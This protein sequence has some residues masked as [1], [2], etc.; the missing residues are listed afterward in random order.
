M[1]ESGIR[2]RSDIGTFKD[3]DVVLQEL[4]TKMVDMSEVDKS[5]I[6]G[7]LAGT[8]QSNMILALVDNMDDL[9]IA[10]ENVAKAG[11]SSKNKMDI[12][13]E[14]TKAKMNELT[15]SL[16]TMYDKMFNSEMIN[17]AI[18]GLTRFIE[19]ITKLDGKTVAMGIAF[20]T[21]LKLM[22][23]SLSTFKLVSVMKSATEATGLFQKMMYAMVTPVAVV[24]T[25]SAVASGAI[26]STGVASAVATP[27]VGGLG[28]GFGILTTGIMSSLKAMGTF[29]MSPLGLVLGALALVIGAVTFAFAHNAKEQ[30]KFKEKV[31]A[32][33]TSV[34]ALNESLEAMNTQGIKDNMKPLQ[35]QQDELQKL[36][37]EKKKSDEAMAGFKDKHDR[38]S[39]A[40]IT[41][42][43]LN[44]QITE[45]L[46]E[47]TKELDASGIAYDSVT[48]KIEKLNESQKAIEDN[49]IPDATKSYE[50]S[51][52]AL[53]GMEESLNKINGLTELS[54]DLQSELLTKYPDAENSLGSVASAQ[55]FLNG[56]I[57]E[58][59]E[60]QREAY[61]IMMGDDEE[62]YN[63]KLMND[64]N[65]KNSVRQNLRDLGLSKEEANAFDFNGYKTL[66]SLKNGILNQ[67]GS[68][69]NSWLSSFVSTS[70]SGY[71]IDLNNF[72][73]AGEAKLAILN[74]IDQ[75]VAK[76]NANMGASVAMAQI[77]TSSMGSIGIKGTAGETLRINM[78]D[79]ANQEI[80]EY[81]WKLQELAINRQRVNT[82]LGGFGGDFSGFSPSS[83][84]GGGIS[85]GDTGGS[86]IPSG[87]DDDKAKKG[88]Q[89]KKE[90]EAE[91]DVA[92]IE[93]KTD[94]YIN[95]Q[96][97]IKK[98][99]YQMDEL[100]RLKENASE[101]EKIN[102]I[103][104]EI[105][106]LGTKRKKLQ[107]NFEEQRKET[108]ALTNLLSSQ[109]HLNGDGTID[110]EHLEWYRRM[111]NE[112]HGE[113]KKRLQEVYSKAVEDTKAYSKLR[114]TDLE[115]SRKE[116]NEIANEKIKLQKE[117]AEITKKQIS[118][119]KDSR[120]KNINEEKDKKIKAIQE[121]KDKQIKALDEIKNL[122]NKENELDDFNENMSKEQK[123]LAELNASRMNTLKD[124][125][126]IGR[127]MV[128]DLE[129]Q[130]NTK[131]EEIAKLQLD[132]SRQNENEKLDKQ[133][134]GITETS[135][136]RVK[137]IE[138]KTDES[139]K[140]I[141]AN[142]ESMLKQIDV[143]A[144]ILGNSLDRN[145]V[146]RFK[147]AN[148]EIS[149]MLEQLKGVSFEN[150]GLTSVFNEQGRKAI[151]SPQPM[152]YKI[153]DL[154]RGIGGNI[155]NNNPITLSISMPMTINGKITDSEMKETEGRF[156]KMIKDGVDSLRDEFYQ[157]GLRY[158]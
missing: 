86:Y 40:S 50:E 11:G 16:E 71:G 35:E 55:E 51:R 118:E 41:E 43:I 150:M 125:S 75:E 123:A 17:G 37:E 124:N 22:S 120:I 154:N 80:K 137:T 31:D 10:K 126:A 23:S 90:R 89:P 91:K 103:E 133:S 130:I 18:V 78:V 93:A 19:A 157:R 53:G 24:A 27:A 142:A 145:L 146:D 28:A 102:L 81:G 109:G 156:T 46:A 34:D 92:D 45:S 107:D 139:I 116:I 3:F 101:K 13:Q 117:I 128:R 70:L 119:E 83:I 26:A 115:N 129:N 58:Q 74:A 149:L 21:T 94:R 64:E 122:Y 65:W 95:L 132:R 7:E 108:I 148:S 77:A 66:N 29:M 68:N 2:L 136:N 4:K 144:S 42:K 44:R 12:F 52:V 56:K 61:A 60:V 6:I 5:K 151:S 110:I 85:G 25:E 15:Q 113:E 20:A 9:A 106:L 73:S 152:S 127:A 8:R 79:K 98:V 69:V 47:K 112:A 143:D 39:T 138:E 54:S 158:S 38:N 131:K 48:G 100:N 111:A 147:N 141:E 82:S 62:F 140:K 96:D 134:E 63:A 155:S 32:N 104:K 49:A 97:A 33:K 87:G 88:K 76:V 72:K 14:G 84:S 30:A 114:N 67:F 105:I 153:Q 57:Q 99:N 121:E 59:G 36:M 135:D 1:G